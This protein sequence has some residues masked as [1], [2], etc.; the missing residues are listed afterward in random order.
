MRGRHFAE[1]RDEKGETFLLKKTYNG[2]IDRFEGKYAVVLI[3][4][5]QD[6]KLDL[7]K[8]L[9]SEETEEGDIVSFSICVKKNRTA[10]AKN[11]VA[12]MIDKL[13]KREI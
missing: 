8:S 7:P 2:I 13:K 9:L 1:H 5:D 3:G 6:E 12:Q 11:A 4:P 10:K